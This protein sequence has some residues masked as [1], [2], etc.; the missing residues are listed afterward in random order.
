MPVMTR[1]LEAR[2]ADRTVAPPFEIFFRL[3]GFGMRRRN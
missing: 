2:E 1:S 3:T